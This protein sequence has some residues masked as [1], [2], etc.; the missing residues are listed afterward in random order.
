MV[1]KNPKKPKSKL[2]GPISGPSDFENLYPA[3]MMQLGVLT[4][5]WSYVEHTLCELLAQLLGSHAK[6]EAAFYSTVNHKARR[7]M[8]LALLKSEDIPDH[9]TPFTEKAIEATKVAADARNKLLHGLFYLD[10]STHE[11]VS[12]QTRPNTKTPKFTQKKILN[13]IKSAIE[14][15]GDA[16]GM[17][18][19]ASIAASY[20]TREEFLDAFPDLVDKETYEAEE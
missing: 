4:A 5:Y 1:C 6:A 16:A 14:K 17:L 18:T 11:I 15:C 13:N 3:E 20:S 8:V 10:K 9:L 7:D 12:V 19:A 2:W